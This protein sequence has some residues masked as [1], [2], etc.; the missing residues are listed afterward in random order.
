MAEEE[1]TKGN[2]RKTEKAIE[3]INKAIDI[4]PTRSILFLKRALYYEDLDNYQMALN[5]IDSSIILCDTVYTAYSIKA[6]I[7]FHL[8]QLDSSIIYHSKAISMRPSKANVYVDRGKTYE[9]MSQPEKAIKDFEKAISIDTT[10][11]LA[12]YYRACLKSITY[13]DYQSAISDFTR[14][15]NIYK[16]KTV[17]DKL[18][19][20]SSFMLRGVCYELTGNLPL[21]CN[22]WS[23]ANELGLKEA[24]EQLTK[25]CNK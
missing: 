25:K 2:D 4:T 20:A 21:A 12:Y 9:E 17:S 13:K 14:V 1:M 16:P 23:R 24:N 3:Y 8:E 22:D 6:N 18:F 19:L 15:I 7:L 11:Y 10:Y 5:S